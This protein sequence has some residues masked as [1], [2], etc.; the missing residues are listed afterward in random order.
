MQSY[1]KKD[2]IQNYDTIIP[3][4]HPMPMAWC[5][6]GHTTFTSNATKPFSPR[7]MQFV[8]NIYHF[9]REY[10]LNWIFFVKFV[11]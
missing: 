2:N 8:I 6:L 1:E 9:G 4:P 11:V 3:F 10:L 7:N 5:D